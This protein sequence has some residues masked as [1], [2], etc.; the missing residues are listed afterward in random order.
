MRY[1][2]DDIRRLDSYIGYD[3][4]V[5][6]LSNTYQLWYNGLMS[7]YSYL[8][9][10][11]YLV[12]AIFRHLVEMYVSG[13][14]YSDTEIL[15][16]DAIEADKANILSKTSLDTRYSISKVVGDILEYGLYGYGHKIISDAIGYRDNLT[17]V[18]YYFN[19]TKDS[20][21]IQLCTISKE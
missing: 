21:F 20:V 12:D 6:D 18:E 14:S 5:Y 4:A 15:I 19:R 17:P 2:T 7:M 9:S 13:Y 10:Y 3:I 11:I 1:I 8:S 16:L